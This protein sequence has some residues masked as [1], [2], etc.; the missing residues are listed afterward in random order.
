MKINTC[1]RGRYGVTSDFSTEGA[2]DQRVNRSGNAVCKRPGCGK[3][4][5][6]NKGRGR[7]RQ[8]C[9]D[10]CARR[11]H[12]AARVSS[13]RVSPS[14]AENPLVGLDSLVRQAA[15]LVRAA[16]DQA[17][18]V[19]PAHVLAQLAE[20]EAARLRAEALASAATLL[21]APAADNRAPSFHKGPGGSAPGDPC[22]HG[23]RTPSGRRPGRKYR[24]RCRAADRFGAP[25]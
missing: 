12:N 16:Q 11:F 17:A 5:P 13:S 18:S 25:A 24:S 15:V 8:F 4:L 22:P 1:G 2:Y 9:S 19:D 7:T 20:A 10:D 23:P 14:V 6:A 3:P 21:R